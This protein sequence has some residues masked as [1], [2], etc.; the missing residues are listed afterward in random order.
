VFVLFASI[1]GR[2]L[3]GSQTPIDPLTVI[4]NATLL[5]GFFSP[6]DTPVIGGWSIGLEVVFYVT[7]PLLMLLRERGVLMIMAATLLTA[8]ISSDLSQQQTLSEGWST[9]VSPANHWIFFCAGVYA[10]IYCDR[11]DLGQS[12]RIAL[13][14]LLLFFG[15]ICSAGATEL[16][17]VTGWRRIALIFSCIASVMLLSKFR[18]TGRLLSKICTLIG[19]ASY[20][21]Y[22]LHP[23]L[24]FIA[25]PFFNMANF[26]VWLALIVTALILATIVDRYFDS[27]LQV[28]I[29]KMGW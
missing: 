8:W 18:I 16:Q 19:G 14:L 1:G 15:L 23:L 3:F 5:F 17:M 13:L 6:S 29:K 27:M 10:R 12:M 11:W 20:P 7:F 4:A 22:L 21:L 25:N 26:Y 2:L 24:F 9:Y 28:R